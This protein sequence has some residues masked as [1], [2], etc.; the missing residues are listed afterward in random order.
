MPSASGVTPPVGSS[1]R[2]VRASSTLAVGEDHLG[3]VAPERQHRHPVAQARV[4]QQP[5]HGAG[6]GLDPLGVPIDPLASTATTT[7][8]P[9][10]RVRTGSRRSST[11]SRGPFG[12]PE[13][14][15]AAARTVAAT[16]TPAI[17]P[18]PGA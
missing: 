11:A 3:A 16:A 12:S 15:S 9:T 8:R 10:V 7:V 2:R 6:G 4:G 13:R 1:A 18:S 14:R 17:G 5:E